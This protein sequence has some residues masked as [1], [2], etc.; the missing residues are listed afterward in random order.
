MSAET[1]LETFQRLFPD[2]AEKV[3]NAIRVAS[4]C[5]KPHMEADTALTDPWVR[6]VRKAMDVFPPLGTDTISVKIIPDEVAD[7]EA[8]DIPPIEV[9]G[10]DTV[11]IGKSEYDRLKALEL[12]RAKVAYGL[13]KIDSIEL[14][15]EFGMGDAKQKRLLVQGMDLIKEGIGR[16]EPG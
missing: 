2:R 13:S 12:D 11:T 14:G 8:P 5:M 16:K 7:L 10:V 9:E 1:K 3:L 6:E 4:H 15:A